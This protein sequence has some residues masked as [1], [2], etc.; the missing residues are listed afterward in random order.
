MLKHD[1]EV[2]THSWWCD[3]VCTTRC[4]VRAVSPSRRA[5]LIV[6]MPFGKAKQS[7]HKYRF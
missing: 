5:I 4:A 7:P 2:L 3:C 6:G 1:A